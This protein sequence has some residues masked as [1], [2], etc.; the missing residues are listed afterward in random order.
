[1]TARRGRPSGY[2]LNP[3]AFADHLGTRSQAGVAADAR[4]SPSHL[5]EMLAGSKGATD[6]VAE[7]LARAVGVRPG[8]LFPELVTF[9][10]QVREFVVPREPVGSVA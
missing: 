1:M 2:T 4:L 5:S 8:T 3:D 9:R 10:V 7:R 6:E